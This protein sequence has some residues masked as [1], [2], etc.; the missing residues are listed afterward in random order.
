MND[1]GR[2]VILGAGPTGLGAAYRLQELGVSDSAVLEARDGPGGLAS[3]HV[4]DHGFT[5]DTG[6]H[7]QFSH[8][9]YYDHLLDRALGEDWVHHERQSWI[10]IKGRFVP[11]PFQNNIHR[12]DPADRDRALAG[13]EQAAAARGGR[14]SANFREWIEATFG[15]GIAELFMLPY[16]FKTWGYA[17]ESLGIRWMGDRVSVPDLVRIQRNVRE[18]RDDVSWGPNQTFRFPLRGGTGAIWKGV[19]GLLDQDRIRFGC[20]VQS[21]DLQGRRVSLADGRWIPYDT[22]ITSLPL[23]ELCRMCGGLSAIAQRAAAAL[24][25]SAVHI[26]GVGLR[27]PQPESLA[28]KCW[29]YFPEAHSPYYRVTV[30]S[31]YSPHNVPPGDGYWSLMAEVCESPV[32]PVDARRLRELTLRAMQEDRLIPPRTAEVSFW[33]RREE[34]GY[35]TPF[36]GRDEV[37][38]AIQGE[39]ERHRVYSRGRFGAWQYEVSNQ[40]H[41][42]MQGVELVDRL[43]GVGEEVTIHRP[44]DVNRG[45]FRRR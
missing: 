44:D 22:L 36:L 25:Y 24:V 32:K 2:I 16:N 40:D 23:D 12:L 39:L 45:A 34:H 30:F 14:P 43:L 37:L 20:P 8:Y 28:R 21:V 17:P 18:S 1:P 41:S 31:N 33:H 7:V 15:T 3:S 13:L 35:P 26:V 11:Y 9:D 6:G 19:A 29:I 42:C 38:A 27:G 4:D 5:W 10:W